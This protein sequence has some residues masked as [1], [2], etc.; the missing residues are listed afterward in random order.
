MYGLKY[1][2]WSRC[3]NYLLTHGMNRTSAWDREGVE[4]WGH[5]WVNRGAWEATCDGLHTWV[6]RHGSLYRMRQGSSVEEQLDVVEPH[7]TQ[8]GTIWEQHALVS[9]A[10]QGIY[11]M[12]QLRHVDELWLRD[13]VTNAPRVR[14]AAQPGWPQL[15]GAHVALCEDAPRVVWAI[16]HV[17]AHEASYIGYDHA[18][19]EVVW[20]HDVELGHFDEPRSVFLEGGEAVAVTHGSGVEVLAFEST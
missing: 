13:V 12:C 20:R 8:G 10:A 6:M 2:E 7:P 15:V 1:V 19:G 18:R 5:D 14:L 17:M 16:T 9:S 11:S 4:V 3:G